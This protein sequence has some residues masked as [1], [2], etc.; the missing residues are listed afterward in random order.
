VGNAEQWYIS[1]LVPLETLPAEWKH[2]DEMSIF[3]HLAMVRRTAVARLRGLTEVERSEVFYPRA[4][5]DHPDEPWTAR[6][7]LRRF[8]EHERE[9]TGQVREIL[10]AWRT[11]LMARLAVERAGLLEQL[12]GLDEAT[13]AHLPVF[14]RWTAKDL[15]AHIAAWDEYFTE[16]VTL[17]LAGRQTEIVG[18]D[19]DERNAITYAERRD[20]PLDRAVA[21]CLEGRAEALQLLKR[22]SDEE[23][24]RR[25]SFPWGQASLRLWTQWRGQHDAEHAA[26]LAAWRQAQNPGN[27]AGARTVLLAALQAGREALL[28][29]AALVPPEE[30]ASR[31]VCGEW[32]LKDVLGHVADW[33]WFCVE[34]LAAMAAGRPPEPDYGGDLETWNREHAS[35]RRDQ[36]WET[37]WADLHA[38]RRA[39]IQVV[40]GFGQTDLERVFLSASGHEG[41]P[42]QWAHA[43]LDHDREHATD[44]RAL[45]SAVW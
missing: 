9:H 42:Y 31:L 45:L 39:L 17:V 32:T 44:L 18:V 12:T 41:T 37:V 30:R 19:P 27:K 7:V 35:A 22:V 20:W 23:L 25:R 16:R 8:L 24:H 10:A 29:V 36:P 26:Q 5:T 4:W 1:R 28:V 40:E 11:H 15:L 43:C 33:E 14:D 3:D 38:A 6:K 2:D 34:N 21:A 13:L